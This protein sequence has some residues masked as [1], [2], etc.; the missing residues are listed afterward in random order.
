M[1]KY[2]VIGGYSSEVL[3]RESMREALEAKPFKVVFS[4]GELQLP[5]VEQ[6]VNG[7]FVRVAWQEVLEVIRSM[8]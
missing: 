5:I 4:G 8:Q 6:D 1:R 3:E 2:R 7:E